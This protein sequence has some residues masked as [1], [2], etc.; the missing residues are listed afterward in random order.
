M[1]HPENSQKRLFA[2]AEPSQ[3]V[4]FVGTIISSIA[5]GALHQF[6]ITRHGVMEKEDLKVV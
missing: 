1:T 4:V 3:H 5:L 6:M 2:M